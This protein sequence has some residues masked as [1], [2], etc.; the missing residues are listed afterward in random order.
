MVS[1]ILRIWQLVHDLC[2]KTTNAENFSGNFVKEASK[3]VSK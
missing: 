2:V 1:K 3:Y